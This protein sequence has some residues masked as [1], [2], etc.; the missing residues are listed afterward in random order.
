MLFEKGTKSWLK[1]VTGV[2]IIVLIILVVTLG[3]CHFITRGN[4]LATCSQIASILAY[5]DY[6]KTE[7]FKELNTA[8]DADWKYLDEQDYNLLA[9]GMWKSGEIDTGGKAHNKEELLLDSW[10][11]RILI[12]GRLTNQKTLDFIVWS[13]GSD[14]ISGTRDD[15]IYYPDTNDLSYYEVMKKCH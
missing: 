5:L 2:L 9:E 12:A 4:Q 15:I 13:K 14:R 3:I 1:I 8:F 7:D 10:K 6:H 11:Q